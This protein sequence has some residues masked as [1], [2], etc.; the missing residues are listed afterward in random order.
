M[1]VQLLEILDLCDEW[2]QPHRFNDYCPNGL[3]VSG[4]DTVSR[5]VTGVTA[6][7]A[8]IEAAIEGDANAI[9]VHHGYFW[10]GDDPCV[11][12][13]LRNRLAL[14]LRHNINLIVYHLPLD[15]QPKFGNNRQLADLLNIQVTGNMGLGEEPALGLT[16]TLQ[17]PVSGE[18]FANLLEQKLNRKPLHLMGQAKTVKRIAWCTGAA[19]D[20]IERAAQL[21]VDAYL[22][23]EVSERTVHLAREY[24]LH[25]YAAG[26]H[27]TERYG[28][29]AL[30]ERLAAQLSIE[31][32]FID[33]DNPV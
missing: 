12:G 6:S 31:A 27:A 14:L 24:G 18:Q 5:V 13:I 25:F 10:R 21:G 29:K 3:Q 8:L 7:M 30:G 28:I 19:Q 4:N 33:I 15:A 16:G 20:G 26:H 2:L 11:R 1:A 22:T 32:R 23:G 9:I 17:K